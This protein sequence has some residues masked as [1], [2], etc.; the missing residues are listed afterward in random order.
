MLR[1]WLVVA[2]FAVVTLLGSAHFDVPIRDPGNRWFLAK[3]RE[4]VVIF[5]ILALVDAVVR[6]RRSGQGL[7]GVLQRLRERWANRR[8]ALAAAGLLAYH[9]V[10]LCYH[11]LK[12]WDVFRAPQD[13]LL[14][15]L[16]RWLFFG[17]S[18]AVLLHDLLGEDTAAYVLTFIYQSFPMIVSIS[19]VAALAFCTRIR[20][21]M[22]AIAAG[23]WMWILGTASYYLIPTLG[24]FWSAPQEFV[25]LP[26]T[27]IQDSQVRYLAQ[28]AHLLADPQ[29][30]DAV[31]QVSAFA[32]LHVAG[33]ATITLMLRYY[34]LRRLSQAFAV[35]LVLTIVATI[36]FGW[37]FVVDDVAGLLI[38]YLSVLLGRW[39]IDPPRRAT[40]RAAVS[41]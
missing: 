38:A 16:D 3:I 20:N 35:W 21:G 34:G 1:L 18:P 33:I 41:R 23:S 22:V 19:F 13:Q 6:N 32:S 27:A 26:H 5:A 4:S 30:H 29:A 7:R 8:L 36:Y 14:L 28:R 37:H 9:L 17:H 10:Y 11:S 39:T 40:R 24:P 31:A 25:G 12:S 2:V 15:D